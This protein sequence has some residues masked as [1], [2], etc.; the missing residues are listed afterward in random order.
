MRIFPQ[1]QAIPKIDAE[2]AEKGHLHIENKKSHPIEPG[3]LKAYYIT[4]DIKS[5]CDF[6]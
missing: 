4:Q 5:L 3:W 6:I 2:I 1:G